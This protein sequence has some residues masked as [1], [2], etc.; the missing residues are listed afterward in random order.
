MYKWHPRFRSGRDSV[1]DDPI[2]SRSSVV[3]CSFKEPEKDIIN[4]DRRTTVKVIADQLKISVSTVHGILTDELY[5]SNV[6]ARWVPRLLKDSEK[7]CRVRCSAAAKQKE[8]Y[9]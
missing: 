5:M 4:R 9:F 6:S 3:M 2:Y 1:E 8:T 7:E